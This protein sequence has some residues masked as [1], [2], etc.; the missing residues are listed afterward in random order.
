MSIPRIIILLSQATS[1]KAGSSEA[2]TEGFCGS[3]VALSGPGI[4][5]WVHSLPR[6]GLEGTSQGQV[7]VWPKYP[8]CSQETGVGENHIWVP[9]LVP[10]NLYNDGYGSGPLP[11]NAD[12][13]AEL[14]VDMWAWG[15]PGLLRTVAVQAAKEWSPGWDT[16]HTVLSWGDA[17][18][19]EW[20]GPWV[21]LGPGRFPALA[22]PG[23]T[24]ARWGYVLVLM[25]GD[26]PGSLPG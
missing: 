20:A 9:A 4:Q 16:R 17:A 14:Q 2:A 18:A 3:L 19:K 7:W 11:T 25:A 1:R 23:I 8:V 10:G 12:R 21:S 6:D 26:N 24:S 15:T 22:I 5:S 13:L